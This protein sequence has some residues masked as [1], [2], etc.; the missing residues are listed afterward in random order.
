MKLSYCFKAI[1]LYFSIISSYINANNP[2]DS[3]ILNKNKYS[4]TSS[5]L[6]FTAGYKTPVNKNR[7]LNSGHGAYIEGGINPGHYISKNLVLGVYAGWAFMDKLWATSF[8]ENFINDYEN[9][10]NKE[11]NYSGIDSAIINTSV[12]LINDSKGKSNVMPGCEMKSF[13]S[14]SMYYG[15]QIKLPYQYFP[16]IKLYKGTMRNH[17]QGDGNLATNGKDFNIFEFRHAMY[18]CEIIILTFEDILHKKNN[19]N[20]LKKN[21][22]GGL[23]VYYESANFKN[24]SLYFYDGETTRKIPFSKY[25]SSIFTT[26]YKHEVSFGLRL[27]YYI[28]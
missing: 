15:I 7:F 13:H 1:I 26:K 11:N 6:L 10:I 9:A 23:S 28:M 27:C 21:K 4:K 20:I 24:S 18:G 16:T 19:Q 2:N 5:V 17:L 3:I 12:K 25:T 14:Y 22:G 8:N